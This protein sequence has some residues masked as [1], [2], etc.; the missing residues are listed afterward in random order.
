MPPGSG[1]KGTGKK[2][3][4]VAN[5]QK[6]SRNTTP[7][8]AASSLPP[9]EPYDPDYLQSRVMLF[10]NINFE[11]IVDSS[12]SNMPS[13]DA[14]GVNTML[15]KLKSLMDSMEKRSAF[16]DRGMRFLALERKGRIDDFGEAETKKTKHKRKKNPDSKGNEGTL[17]RR[18]HM[19]DILLTFGLQRSL[20]PSEMP[21]ASPRVI[22]SP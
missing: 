14:R 8:P 5:M 20:R 2:N 9:E 10:G 15:D 6:Q 21:N 3:S 11:H 13:L 4:A 16:Y 22:T 17:L 19:T 1:N 12:A 7:A 18:T